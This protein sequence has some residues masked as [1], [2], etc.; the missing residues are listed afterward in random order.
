MATHATSS[1]S[2][3]SSKFKRPAQVALQARALLRAR[4]WFGQPHLALYNLSYMRETRRT[5][6]RTGKA[7]R[8]EPR[9][10]DNPANKTKES[11]V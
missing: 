5:A 10:P 1:S 7:G 9:L 6:A 11:V 3:S 4:D 2:S 8:G